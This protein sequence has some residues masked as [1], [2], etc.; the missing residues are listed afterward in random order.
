MGVPLLDLKAHHEPLHKEVMAAIEQTFRSQ[1]F[2]LGPEVSKL[3]ERVASYCQTSHGIGVSSGTDALLIA[4]MAIG[5]GPGDEVI[6]TPYSFFATAGAVARLGA[7]PVLVDIDPRT[8]N[9]DPSKIGNA[10]T[11]KTKAMIP[12]HLYGQCADMAPILDLAQRHNLK[13]IEDAAQAIGAEY[14]EGR[15]AGGMGTVGCLSFFPARTW[16]L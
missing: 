11:S 8:Y 7:K 13:V 14:R 10:I 15:R 6:T 2:I 1:A 9:I 3:E 12:V 5:I 4:L 16:V